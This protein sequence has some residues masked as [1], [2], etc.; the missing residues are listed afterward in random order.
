VEE[1]TYSLHASDGSTPRLK[2]ELVT[3]FQYQSSNI[4]STDISVVMSN[5]LS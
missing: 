2:F 5:V 4:T 3:G 1:V